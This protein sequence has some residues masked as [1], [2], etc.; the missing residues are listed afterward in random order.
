MKTD[1]SHA[2]L[3]SVANLDF[4]NYKNLLVGT[5][6]VKDFLHGAFTICKTYAT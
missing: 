6:T 5:T 1:D 3:W 4:M 2:T